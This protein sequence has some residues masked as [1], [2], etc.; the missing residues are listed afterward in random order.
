MDE[1]IKSLDQIPSWRELQGLDCNYFQRLK[2]LEKAYE[3]LE[4]QGENVSE[5]LKERRYQM[6]EATMAYIQSDLEDTESQ[7]ESR[8]PLSNLNIPQL[9]RAVNLL[10]ELAGKTNA[11]ESVFKDNG[12]LKG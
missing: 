12:W 8:E 10:E 5:Q 6:I 9:R 11:D 1:I 3:Q 2:Q 7:V 4:Q